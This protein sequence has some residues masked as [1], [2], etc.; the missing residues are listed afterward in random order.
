MSQISQYENYKTESGTPYSAEEQATFE[1]TGVVPVSGKYHDDDT[2]M[3]TKSI[4]LNDIISSGFPE[5]TQLDAGKVLGVKND[6]TLEWVEKLPAHDYLDK[7]KVLTVT[8]SHGDTVEWVTPSGG[9]GS[10]WSYTKATG[11]FGEKEEKPFPG[12]YFNQTTRELPVENHTYT[13]AS[14]NVD[15]GGGN[16]TQVVAIKLTQS[17]FP[18]AYVQFKTS[19]SNVTALRHIVVYNGSTSLTRMYAAGA[20]TNGAVYNV[21]ATLVGSDIDVSVE[22]DGW[23]EIFPGNESTVLVHIF[24]DTYNILCSSGTVYGGY[25]E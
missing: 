25:V 12:E 18:D 9:G 16:D 11:T 3:V 6:G 17:D 14:G 22:K 24:G 13:V 7:D 4:N 10:G 15:T 1:S 20:I 8:G 23:N 2:S 5:H 19:D 21:S